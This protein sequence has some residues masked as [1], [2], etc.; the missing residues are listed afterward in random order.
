MHILSPPTGSMVC[1][2]SV[3]FIILG[4]IWEYGKT[5]KPRQHITGVIVRER[6]GKTIFAYAKIY[7]CSS[8]VTV[9]VEYIPSWNVRDYAPAQALMENLADMKVLEHGGVCSGYRSTRT[10]LR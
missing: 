3:F 1:T 2:I 10:R 5:F 9:G 4:P 6:R 8:I 7:L